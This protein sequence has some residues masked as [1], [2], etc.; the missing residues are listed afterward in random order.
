MM[1]GPLKLLPLLVK[2]NSLAP[3][4][5]SAPEVEI[6]AKSKVY[7]W[8]V[9][10][11][12]MEAGATGAGIYMLGVAEPESLKVTLSPSEKIFVSPVQFGEVESQLLAELSPTQ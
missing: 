2:S 12:V 11:T 3:A 4:L 5:I 7:F 6:P 10:L 1:I 8:L 9:L